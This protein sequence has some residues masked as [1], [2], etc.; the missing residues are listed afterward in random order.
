MNFKPSLFFVIL[1]VSVLVHG[2][3]AAEDRN[4]RPFD[5]IVVFGDSL[6]DPGNFFALTG[7]NLTPPDFGMVPSDFLI[8]SAPYAMGGNHF[9]NGPTWIE[10]L[11]RPLGFSWSVR[12][13][14]ARSTDGSSNYAVGGAR[15]HD[16]G[17]PIQLSAQVSAFLLR[18]M[19][20]IAP[21]GALY[22]VAIGG[23]DI[24]D[25]IDAYAFDPQTAAEILGAAVLSVVQNIHQLYGAGARTFL[26]SNAPD[27]GVTPAI[28]AAGI[29]VNPGIPQLATGLSLSFNQ[30]LA[31]ALTG[32]AA[33]PGIRIVQ[34]DAFGTLHTIQAQPGRFGFSNAT[35]ACLQPNVPPFHCP[36]PDRYFFW[37]GIHPTRAGHAAIAFFAAKALAGALLEQ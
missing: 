3:A 35:T 34:F 23:N 17:T 36:Q 24:R 29:Y 25:A 9:S 18:D 26:V 13:A 2:A 4:H 22:V 19:G 20:G 6:S 27:L 37:D 1:A 14:M 7:E 15:A 30:G 28:V 12:P 32:L 33:L 10:Q 21:G 31:N 11:A 5:R 8:P 16:D